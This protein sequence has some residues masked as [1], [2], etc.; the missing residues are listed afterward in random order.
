MRCD[1]TAYRFLLW[2]G[3]PWPLIEKDGQRH[4]APETVTTRRA[5]HVW[6]RRIVGHAVALAGLCPAWYLLSRQ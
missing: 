2:V 5:W 4:Q 6:A 3:S 1:A